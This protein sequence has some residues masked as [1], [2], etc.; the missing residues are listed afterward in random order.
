MSDITEVSYDEKPI[1]MTSRRCEMKDISKNMAEVLLMV[2][3]Y[4]KENDIKNDGMPLSIYHEFSPTHVLMDVG[5]M[6][7]IDTDGEGE[8]KKS[9]IPKAKALKIVHK[10]DYSDLPKT[11]GK[12]FNYIKENGIEENGS[13]WEQYITDPRVEPN[14]SKWIT[15]IFHPIK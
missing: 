10:G 5:M 4:L 15:H 1:L 9:A 8:I 2:G 6:V 13:P 12:V 3:N 14:K 7:D 11:Y